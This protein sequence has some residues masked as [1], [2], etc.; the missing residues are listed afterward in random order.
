MYLFTCNIGTPSG[1]DKID[2]N[3]TDCDSL[4]GEDLRSE[5]NSWLLYVKIAV[6]IILIVMGS[7][8]FGKAFISSDEDAMKKAQKKFIMRLII[9]LVIFFIPALVNILLNIADQVWNISNGNGTCQI[10][11]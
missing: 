7:L 11:F 4:L 5:I 6:P 10:K 8:D 1:Y 3:I 9:A 2:N